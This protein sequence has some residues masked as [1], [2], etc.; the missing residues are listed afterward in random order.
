MPSFAA[1]PEI[2]SIVSYFVDS[3]DGGEYFIKHAFVTIKSFFTEFHYLH[4][5]LT[6]AWLLVKVFALIGNAKID[7]RR[8]I[9]FKVVTQREFNFVVGQLGKIKYV[10]IIAWNFSG[11]TKFWLTHKCHVDKFKFEAFGRILKGRGA[12]FS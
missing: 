6:N 2:S 9:R 7:F 3:Q 5:K 11:I 8:E 10:S 12:K 4:Q 1:Y